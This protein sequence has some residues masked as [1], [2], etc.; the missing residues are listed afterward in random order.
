MSTNMNLPVKNEQRSVPAPVSER[1][2]R[3]LDPLDLFE[4]MQTDLTRFLGAP[5]GAW[6]FGRQLRQ[7]APF[8]TARTPR[9][10]VFERNGDIVVKAELP[11]V[12]KE[13]VDLSI[14]GSDLILRA[15]QREEREVKEENWYRMERNYGSIYRRLPLPEGV[16][17][18]RISASLHDGVLDVTI[19]KPKV[20]EP[21]AKK[22][23]IS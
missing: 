17:T 15:E 5:F 1:R 12:K 19:P 20:Q 23:A 9:V 10:D 16:Q 7:I 8:P 4:D 22:I 3:W 21:Q 6:P 18:D 13:D 14:E 11:G 2:S